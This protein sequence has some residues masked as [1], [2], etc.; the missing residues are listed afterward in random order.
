MHVHIHPFRL[1]SSYFFRKGQC[2]CGASLFDI[3][4][5]SVIIGSS[6]VEKYDGWYVRLIP[7][8]HFQDDTSFGVAVMLHLETDIHEIGKCRMPVVE[9]G[10]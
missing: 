6:V 1:L 10:E 9:Y 5:E 3:Y 8:C 2:Q 7:V 4:I